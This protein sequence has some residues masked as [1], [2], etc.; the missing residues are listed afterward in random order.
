MKL[1][2]ACCIALAS[3][4]NHVALYSD[5]DVFSV[6][7]TFREG[8]ESSLP[9]GSFT[10]ATWLRFRS[11]SG[12]FRVAMSN[13]DYGLNIDL[14]VPS[15]EA[16]FDGQSYSVPYTQ[17]QAFNGSRWGHIAH[18]YDV[19]ARQTLF[20]VNGQLIGSTPISSAA[21]PFGGGRTFGPG[22]IEHLYFGIIAE[23]LGSTP[24]IFQKFF[25]P[26]TATVAL[27]DETCL[28]DVALSAAQVAS[29][30]ANGRDP[31]QTRVASPLIAYDFEETSGTTL[32]NRGTLGAA[33]DGVLGS[34]PVGAQGAG[35]TSLGCEADAHALA[36]TST[37][38][39]SG[40]VSGAMVPLA[41]PATVQY[42]LEARAEGSQ[43]LMHGWDANG[44]W[45]D[46]VITRLPVVGTLSLQNW[47]DPSEI[48]PVTATP[49]SPLGHFPVYKWRL[50]VSAADIAFATAANNFAVSI[51]Y[52]VDDDGGQRSA[53]AN[54]RVELISVDDV[55][56]AAPQAVTLHEDAAYKAL[57]LHAT[58][59]DSHYLTA[60]IDTLPSHGRLFVR[61]REST[62]AG[63]PPGYAEVTSAFSAFASR[64]SL[65]QYASSVR[66]VSSFWPAGDCLAGDAGGD[67]QCYPSWHAN[68]VLGSPSETTYGG[69]RFTWAPMT[70]AAPTA[71][72]AGGDSHLSFAAWDPDASYQENDPGYSEFI[73]VG[74]EQPVHVQALI[75]GENVGMGS[76]V[77]VKADADATSGSAGVGTW[78][79]IYKGPADSG[80][81]SYHALRNSMSYF[82]PLVCETSFL[83][84]HVG[85]SGFQPAPRS[86]TQ[87]I[88][89]LSC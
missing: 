67:G 52:V 83:T 5:A 81:S 1:V 69:S 65:T 89:A 41:Q 4:S 17:V 48:V 54:A 87:R 38:V 76:I 40:A 58:D 77:S 8:R 37:P 55:P 24:G 71:W 80:K 62:I 21:T 12:A 22:G 44:H 30:H 78:Q 39:L 75:V 66:R 15:V 61:D 14:K 59:S 18:V 46:P 32:T 6:G 20:Y 26:F 70:T 31:S 13:Y 19:A 84:S 72:S 53:E 56:A 27:Y 10:L 25:A 2:F 63:L 43:I 23:E 16:Y 29:V 9:A 47:L 57:T 79:S 42:A 73:E 35:T 33:M 49:F 64:T 68:Q 28:W 50:D 34:L 36:A 3:C 85:A 86:L 45:F 51:G 7:A 82:R 60:I 11:I 88:Q 74:F